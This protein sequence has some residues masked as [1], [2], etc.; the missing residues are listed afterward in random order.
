M[1]RY[2]IVLAA[3]PFLAC[4]SVDKERGHDQLAKELK[5]R[6]GAETG[7]ENGPPDDAR[8][9]K[10][11]D[12]L[13]Q[14]GLTPERA[15]AVA[16]LNNPALQAMYEDL[17]I[18]QAD[19]VQAG[20]LDN[21]RF[22]A[23]LGFPIAGSGGLVEQQLGLVQNLLTLIILPL[24]KSIAADQFAADVSRISSAAFEAA[25][26]ARKA[27]IEAQAA[28]R[29]VELRAN[30]IEAAAGS[31]DFAERLYAAGNI[32]ELELVEQQA[33]HEQAKLDLAEAQQHL[34]EAREHVNRSLGLFGARTAWKLA[35]G[36]DETIPPD[37]SVEGLEAL[38][39]KQRLD[40][41]AA[42]QQAELFGRAVNLASSSRWVGALEVGVDTHRD[43]DGPRVLG[44]SLSIELPIFDQRQAVL[45]KLQ[46][47]RRQ[48]Q[49]LRDSAAVNARSRVRQAYAA[50]KVSRD[51]VAH[52]QKVLVPL[53]NKA[54]ELAQLQYNG[55]QI[56][57]F[58]L[59]TTKREQLETLTG[60]IEGLR[61]LWDSRAE[62]EA[63]A[64]GRLQTES[65]RP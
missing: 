15:V 46:A 29:A 23:A 25:I 59:M 55:M 30:V 35:Q 52:Y 45:A 5:D 4:A 16:L 47:Q 41:R 58:Q 54:V 42:T 53:R 39:M 7:W 38:A 34:V 61:M 40:V 26:D 10:R 43:P 57:L 36:L 6:V 37:L 65:A 63:A 64:G 60:Y 13:L 32:L 3:L 44:P 27:V 21:P 48:S 24:R 49:R 31:R 50:Y 12:E 51:R 9:S 19:M 1:P 28:T 8:V 17:G 18:A 14:A 33:M 20:L 56:G 2:F 11:L 62:L 22:S